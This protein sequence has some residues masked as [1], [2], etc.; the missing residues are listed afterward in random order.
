MVVLFIYCIFFISGQSLNYGVNWLEQGSLYVCVVCDEVEFWAFGT[1]SLS[2]LPSGGWVRQQ[3][4][5]LSLSSAWLYTD[6]SR[7]AFTIGVSLHS[8]LMVNMRLLSI[9][10]SLVFIFPLLP[11]TWSTFPHVVSYPWHACPAGLRVLFAT[12]VSQSSPPCP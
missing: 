3:S 11:C 5:L 2:L 4:V 1:P 6:W 8:F 12:S 7:Y 9:L 10:S